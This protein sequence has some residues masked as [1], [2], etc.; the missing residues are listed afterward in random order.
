MEKYT[1]LLTSIMEK[2]STCYYLRK[3]TDE[4]TEVSV[5]EVREHLNKAYLN[6][7]FL[8]SY[9]SYWGYDNIIKELRE[10][11]TPEED[12]ETMVMLKELQK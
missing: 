5:S 11:G 4:H 3:I 6:G 1:R 12:I 9:S 2:W 10:L 7:G 8:S